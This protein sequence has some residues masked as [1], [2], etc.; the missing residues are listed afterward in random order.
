MCYAF[1]LKIG[2]CFCSID[3]FAAINTIGNAIADATLTHVGI[4]SSLSGG[5]RIS[6][7]AHTIREMPY[8]SKS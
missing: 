7:R 3:R 4:L 5:K 2:L 1:K 8:E 6:K